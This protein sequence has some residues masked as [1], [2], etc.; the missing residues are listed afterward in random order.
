MTDTVS[1]PDPIEATSRNPVRRLSFLRRLAPRLRPQLWP[2]LGAGVLIL[3]SSAI[4]LA[5]PL[6]VR[7]LFDAAFLEAN[8]AL[9]DGIA[10]FLLG[11][12]AVQA[13]VNFGQS[14]LTATISERVIATLRIDLFDALVAQSPGF[15]ANRR[16]GEL[17]S[18]IASD[19]GLVQQVLRFGIPELIRQA[20]FLTGALVIV[21]WTSPRLTL[22]TLTAIPFA[23]AV[24]WFFGVRVRRISTGIQDT[25]AG[26]VARA[27]QVFTQIR[28]VQSFAREP[29]ERGRFE[30]EVEETYRGGLRRALARAGLT[31]AV[32]FSAFGAI[33]VVF[34]EGGRLVLAGQLTA[35]TLIAFL[36]YAAF[37]AGAISAVAGF[38]TNVQEAAGAARRIFEHLDREPAIR[39]PDAPR[40]LP[41]RVTGHVRFENVTFR[42]AAALPWV[43]HGFDLEIRPGETVALV[44]SSGA[45]KST[46]ASLIPRFFDVEGGRVTVEGIDVRDLR[47]ADL[48][49]AIGIVPQEPMLFAG[50]IRENLMYGRLDA[51]EEEMIRAARDA[52]A[53]EFICGFPDGYDQAV[54]ERGVTLSGGQRQRMA[55]ARVMLKRPSILILD[56]ASSSLDA[57]S[58]R[59]VQ[60]ALSV[61][62]EN[63][64]TLVIA[65]RLSTV[66]H[67]DRIVVLDGG[68]IEDVGTHA[69]LL[70]RSEVYSRLYR[71]QFEA[72]LA[73]V[74]ASGG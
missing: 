31:G 6:V 74:E 41:R 15:Y 71:R 33:V 36:L 34:W 25:L 67:A 69:D 62:M 37:I 46:V 39:D 72:A 54:G 52:H 55:I 64:T 60:D 61:L 42:Y 20:L 40:A 13:V 17:S 1:T 32:T 24:A 14:Y 66:I 48:R 51:G 63:R 11:L 21:T 10:L 19:A 27:E 70:A 3:I 57:E 50:T 53:Q 23:I 26:A 18:R 44:G 38:W 59:L 16:T 8:P 28:V 9:L 30:D 7:D 29:Y 65:H 35:G 47:L 43:L 73:S 22:V 4:G 5:F 58:E 12:F 2:L 56:E 68:V 45:G 49:G